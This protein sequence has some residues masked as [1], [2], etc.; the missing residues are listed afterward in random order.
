MTNSFDGTLYTFSKGGSIGFRGG[1][2]CVTTWAYSFH[3]I[4][5]FIGKEALRKI[6]NGNGLVFK[7]V[8]SSTL[9]AGKMDVVEMMCV[10]TTTEA[11]FLA[12]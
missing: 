1:L 7:A 8:S 12:A 5:I 3:N 11:V 4:F 9:C 10:I 6:D 2:G